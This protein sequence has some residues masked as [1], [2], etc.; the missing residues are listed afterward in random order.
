MAVTLLLHVSNSE[1]IKVDVDEMPKPTDIVIIGKNP[2]ERSD[3][4]VSFLDE[5]VTTVIFPWWRINYVQ[6]LPS[7]DDEMEFPLPFRE[8]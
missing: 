2:R 7:G 4:E 1:P 3:K 6:V 5:G 8:D